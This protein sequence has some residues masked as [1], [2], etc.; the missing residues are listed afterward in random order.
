MP[1]D[2][3]VEIDER[4]R[5]PPGDLAAERRLAGA[6]EADQRQVAVLYRGAQSIRSR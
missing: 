5:E 1:F 2:L 6:H 3:G 4:A